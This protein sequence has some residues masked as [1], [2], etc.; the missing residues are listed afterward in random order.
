MARGGEGRWPI[1]AYRRVKEDEGMGGGGRRR[2]IGWMD[3]GGGG[4]AR[5]GLTRTPRPHPLSRSLPLPSSS[6]F[7]LGKASGG[8]LGSDGIGRERKAHFR[9]P[10]GAPCVD[11]EQR[12]RNGMEERKDDGQGG[13]GKSQ[14]GRGEG[15]K[16]KGRRERKKRKKMDREERKGKG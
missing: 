10:P 9:P 1:R 3:G 11:E 14:R 13:E 8:L 6:F 2:A 16:D 12:P 4:F 5:L 7:A 15:R